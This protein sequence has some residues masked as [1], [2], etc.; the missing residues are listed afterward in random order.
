MR[1]LIEKNNP[2]KDNLIQCNIQAGN[3]T[4]NTEVKINFTLPELSATKIVR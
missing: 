2:K 1:R 4:T 3:I